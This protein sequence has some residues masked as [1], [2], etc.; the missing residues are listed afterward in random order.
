MAPRVRLAIYCLPALVTMLGGCTSVTHTSL[1]GIGTVTLAISGKVSSAVNG[2]PLAGAQVSASSVG[3][4]A[5]TGPTGAYSLSGEVGGLVSH[6]DLVFEHAGYQT[7][8][9][10]VLRTMTTMDIELTPQVAAHTGQ[11]VIPIAR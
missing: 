10:S 9:V 5:T 6:I 3:L 8:R 1:W 7:R 4:R 11:R 2:S